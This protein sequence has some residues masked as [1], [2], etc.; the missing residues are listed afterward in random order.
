[1]CKKVQNNK[2]EKNKTAMMENVIDYF[3]ITTKPKV[4]IFD[5]ESIHIQFD[6]HRWSL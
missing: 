1:M 2:R 6:D 3:S 4:T 5:D